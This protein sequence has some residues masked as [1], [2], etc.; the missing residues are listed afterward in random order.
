MQFSNTPALGTKTAAPALKRT[1]HWPSS[2]KMSTSSPCFFLK[3]CAS[4]SSRH[5]TGG[6]SPVSST[7][8][9]SSFESGS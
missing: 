8:F 2:S 9:S 5:S 7:S 4:S 6:R 1:T 3:Y